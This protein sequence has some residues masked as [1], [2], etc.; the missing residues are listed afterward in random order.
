MLDVNVDET[1][2]YLAA[3]KLQL[4]AQEFEELMLGTEANMST[5]RRLLAHIQTMQ[6][7]WW[8]E[9]EDLSALE[10]LQLQRDLE[11]LFKEYPPEAV[12]L[13][14]GG[15]TADTEGGDDVA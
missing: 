5:F 8:V 9:R 10:E 7:P 14:V 13:A 6:L 1:L 15:A 2:D 3:L 11:K 12:L 4:E